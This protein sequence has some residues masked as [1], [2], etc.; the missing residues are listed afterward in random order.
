[1]S[2]PYRDKLDSSADDQ[3]RD[4]SGFRTGKR[5]KEIIPVPTGFNKHV[6][7]LRMCG[8][9]FLDF[10]SAGPVQGQGAVI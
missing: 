2:G 3:A 10:V 1:M 8:E 4:F 7:F 6:S 5:K 9:R